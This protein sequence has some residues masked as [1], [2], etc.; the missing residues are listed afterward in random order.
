M[1]EHGI[2]YLYGKNI[3]DR[4]L[5]LITIA[6][7]K[8]REW[9]LDEAKKLGLVQR[10]QESIERRPGRVPGPSRDIPQDGRRPAVSS[11]A[12][13]GERCG[14]P[15]AFLLFA[16][17]PEPVHEVLF[18]HR[19]RTAENDTPLYGY[20]LLEGNDD[21]GRRGR[22]GP[23]TVIGIGQ[24]VVEKGKLAA[25]ISL[26]VRDDFQNRGIGSIL[27]DYVFAA[28]Q[29]E[30]ILEMSATVLRENDKMLH[31]FYKTGLPVTVTE[32]SDT[33]R[34]TMPMV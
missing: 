7:P 30:G 8:F 32:G 5:S 28:A 11:A 31:L 33:V 23:E 2:A 15:Q 24:Y 9:L 21:P 22:A 20:R 12:G 26:L 19:I 34:L 17:R 4:A 10:D 16:F 14:K 25:E 3:R 27:M 29:R 18:H 1:T 13:Q 6:H